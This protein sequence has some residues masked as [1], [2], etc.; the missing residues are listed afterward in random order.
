MLLLEGIY[1]H[2]PFIDLLNQEIYLFAHFSALFSGVISFIKLRVIFEQ[3]V[4]VKLYDKCAVSF[5]TPVL[6]L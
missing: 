1:I 3:N 5:M 2:V 6:A 4:V